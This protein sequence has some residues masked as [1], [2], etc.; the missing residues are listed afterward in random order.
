MNTSKNR[1]IS[2]VAASAVSTVFLTGYSLAADKTASTATDGHAYTIAVVGASPTSSWS[3]SLEC[4]ARAAVEG[5]AVKLNYQAA[6]EWSPTTQKPL[7]DT[8]LATNPDALVIVPTDSTALQKT[9]NE[10][11]KRGI[12]IIVLDS[13]I[14]DPSIAASVITTDNY[15]AGETAFDGIAKA[16]DGGKLLVLATAPGIASNDD[17]VNGFKEAAAKDGR[18]QYLGVQYVPDLSVVKAAQIVTAA[19]AKD[20]DIAGIFAVNSALTDGVATG[21]KQARIK[22]GLTVIGFDAAPPTVSLV[23]DGQVQAIVAQQPFDF[24]KQGVEQALAALEGR[25]TESKI[26]VGSFLITKDNYQ[27]DGANYVYRTQCSR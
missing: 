7:L 25:P 9:L 13:T 23:A 4:G 6:T 26:D 14:K 19:L 18:F 8:V 20:P 12:K 3:I 5:T 27:G 21:V 15:S 11:H 2:I 16:R 24:G 1:L 17:R 22:D 10:A